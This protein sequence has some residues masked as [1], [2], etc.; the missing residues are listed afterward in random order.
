MCL[1]PLLCAP[2]LALILALQEKFDVAEPLLEQVLQL[3]PSFV[4]GILCLASCQE[5]LG[6]ID[7]AM[8]SLERASSLHPELSEWCSREISRLEADH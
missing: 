4:E 7:L 1:N 2:Q 3:E 8:K 6:K 5:A